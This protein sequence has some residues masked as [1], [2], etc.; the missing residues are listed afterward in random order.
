MATLYAKDGSILRGVKNLGWILRNWKS[1]ESVD[2][3]SAPPA[4]GSLAEVV[5]T[6]YTDPKNTPGRVAKYQTLFNCSHSCW[7]WL[8]RPVLN[9]LP[10][11]WNGQPSRIGD[12]TPYPG[13]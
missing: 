9:G 1:I 8:R 2:V 10:L 4:R 12:G 3:R 13:K 5:L 11:T 7:T 6:V